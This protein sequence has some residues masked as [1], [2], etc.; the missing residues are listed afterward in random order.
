VSGDQPMEVARLPFPGSVLE[1]R[2]VGAALYVV[3]QTWKQQEDDPGIWQAEVGVSGFD[4]AQAARPVAHPQ[5]TLRGFG[6]VVTATDTYLFVAMSSD[7]TEASWTQ[8]LHVFGI[9]DP[10][11]VVR[12]VTRIPLNGTL[13]DKFKVHQRGD[14]V[15]VVTEGPSAQ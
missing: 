11:G 9:A 15:A 3:S 12:R 14:V 10:S 2:L 1:S 7:E 6:S 8:T 13:R 5:I 4:L